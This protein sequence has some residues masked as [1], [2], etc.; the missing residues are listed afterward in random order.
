MF[1][2]NV[3]EKGIEKM[4]R[5]CNFETLFVLNEF[6]V[7]LNKI[8]LKLFLPTKH[9]FL[10]NPTPFQKKN[11]FILETHPHLSKSLPPSN[12]NLTK[13]PKAR[14]V[15]INF[16]SV[17]IKPKFSPQAFHLRISFPQGLC[18]QI[19]PTKQKNNHKLTL[20]NRKFTL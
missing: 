8:N 11:S 19:S 15:R 13:L 17:L 10:K 3:L 1:L 4:E 7:F 5:K 18:F 2:G 20:K 14:H 6:D 16:L 9:P 12:Q